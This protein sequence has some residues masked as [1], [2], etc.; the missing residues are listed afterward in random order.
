MTA[1]TRAPGEIAGTLTCQALSFPRKRQSQSSSIAAA[2]KRGPCLLPGT[3]KDRS[4]SIQSTHAGVPSA[5]PP[6]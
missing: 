2:T 3:G 6:W 5:V 4:I 1:W